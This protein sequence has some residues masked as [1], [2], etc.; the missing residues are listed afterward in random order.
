MFFI[1]PVME[2]ARSLHPANSP[3][4][5]ARAA[6]SLLRSSRVESS[7]RRPAAFAGGQ[8]DRPR[9]T[10]LDAG[11]AGE[12]VR[13][14]P[15]PFQNRPHHRRWAGLFAGATTDACLVIHDDPEQ[16]D[17]LY[18][19]ADESEWAEELTPGTV[20]EECGDQNKAEK[21]PPS[22]ADCRRFVDLEG[23][24]LLDQIGRPDKGGHGKDQKN[25][26]RIALVQRNGGR[27]C[28]MI[29]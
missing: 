18:E 5:T 9:R 29:S 15:V 25:E 4:G 12:A 11:S 7:L 28:L 1:V 17:F 27:D 16:A 13:N 19:P 22:D 24:D 8:T 21:Y 2:T 14:H 23:I 20:N 10:D 26:I 3:A 6:P